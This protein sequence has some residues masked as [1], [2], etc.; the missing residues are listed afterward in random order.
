M[1]VCMYVQH[2]EPMRAEGPK[3]CPTMHSSYGTV[4][5]RVVYRAGPNV[6]SHKIPDTYSSMQTQSTVVIQAIL[7]KPW[8][9]V[10]IHLSPVESDL[11]L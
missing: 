1:Y 5:G 7:G 2:Q 10:E 9:V 11:R 8:Q 3:E 6:A 4:F